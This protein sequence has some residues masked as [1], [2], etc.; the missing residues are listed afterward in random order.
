MNDYSGRRVMVLGAA[1][2][3]G[4]WVARSLGQQGAELLLVARDRD[5]A[6]RVFA[7]YGVAGRVLVQDLEDIVSVRTMLEEMRPAVVFN[8]A[9]YGVDPGERDEALARRLNVDLVRVLC[10]A[11]GRL[12]D[13]GWPGM[14][15]VHA[16]SSAEYGSSAGPLAEETA[17]RP[18][19]FYG[20]SKL[21]GTQAVEAAVRA[22]HIRAITAR[23]FNVYGPG[24]HSGRLL[25]SLLE[26]ARTRETL[27]L[28]DGSQRRDFAYV[29]DVARA[30]AALGLVPSSPWPTV[31]LAT[32]QV[33]PV[34]TFTETA[35][36]LLGIPAQSLA[37]GRISGN[38]N[39][40]DYPA[41][42]VD[43]LQSLLGWTPTADYEDGVLRTCLFT[44]GLALFGKNP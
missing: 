10:E 38:Q 35:A 5:Q 13:P 1:G 25:P 22:G 9:G 11:M 8:L 3:L 16:G 43:R 29:E 40:L 7:D 41:V 26:C 27:A 12:R 30:V 4:R 18:A 39:A 31:N 19:G 37:F 2:F 24:E 34:R 28:T 33:L 14:H 20:L 15:L 36:R 32:G 44:G 42:S 21:E 6:K 17:P 23:L